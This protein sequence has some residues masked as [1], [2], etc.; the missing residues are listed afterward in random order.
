M[1]FAVEKK[2]NKKKITPT[3]NFIRHEINLMY[4][5]KMK[6]KNTPPSEQ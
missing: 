4:S 1:Y 2:K 5:N 3:G 6:S